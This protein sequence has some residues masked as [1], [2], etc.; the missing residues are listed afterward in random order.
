MIGIRYQQQLIL[1]SKKTAIIVKIFG[2]SVTFLLTNV[3]P[4]TV[5]FS[6]VFSFK[7]GMASPQII[8]TH[9]WKIDEKTKKFAKITVDSMMPYE[10]E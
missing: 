1:H 9:F 10:S 8:N 4:V 5:T 6:S 7:K 3:G 2:Q